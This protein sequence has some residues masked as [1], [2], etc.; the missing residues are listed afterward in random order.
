MK[1]SGRGGG[2]KYKPRRFLGAILENIAFFKNGYFKG[3]NAMSQWG[4]YRDFESGFLS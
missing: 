1:S 2:Y 4:W 3:L